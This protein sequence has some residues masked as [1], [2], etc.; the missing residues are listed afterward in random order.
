MAAGSFLRVKVRID[1]QEPL[2]RGFTREEDEEEKKRRINKPGDGREVDFWC[3]FEYEFLPDFCYICGRLGHVDKECR[4]KLKKGEVAQYGA[5]M[6]AFIP[7]RFPEGNHGSWTDNRSYGG[8]KSRGSGRSYSGGGHRSL[9]ESDSDS[10]RKNNNLMIKDKGEKKGDVQEVASPL[11]F[12]PPATS[13]NVRD[14]GIN[15]QLSFGT[16]TSTTIQSGGG[17]LVV[18]DAAKANTAM[19]EKGRATHGVKEG[20]VH[21]E[22]QISEGLSHSS[23]K[24]KL[25]GKKMSKFKRKK[26]VEGN[27]NQQGLGVVVGEKRQGMDVDVVE[28]EKDSQKK[29][30]AEKE[31]TQNQEAG[32]S[33]QLRKQK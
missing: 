10:W 9:S 6:K 17:V 18:V 32:M 28:E 3:R 31:M 15:K 20:E 25:D 27:G 33:I 7:K 8:S 26:R 16:T 24:E 19:T 21:V 13:E 1:I 14:G 30:R 22:G 11:K 23:Q 2:M 4:S 12:D 29:A 5:W